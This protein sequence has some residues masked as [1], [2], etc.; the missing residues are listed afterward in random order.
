MDEEVQMYLDDAKENMANSFAHLE[1]E[2]VKLRA[3]KANPHMLSGIKVDYYGTITPLA[4][5][6]NVSTSDAHTLV[7]QPWEKAMIDPIEKE[8]RNSNMGFN[9][10]NN[11][12]LIRINVP[13]LTEERR[14]SIVK[15]VKSEGE[16]AKISIRNIRKEVMDEFKKMLKEGLSEDATKDAEVE[17]QKLTDACVKQ[18]DEAVAVKEIEVMKV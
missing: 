9:P 16:K 4:Q 12:D 18:I 13:M 3:G 7:I 2:L 11:G 8:I 15:E 6:A 14:R 10:V 1:A 5:I 17:A